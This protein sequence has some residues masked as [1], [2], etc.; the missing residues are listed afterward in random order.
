MSDGIRSASNWIS[1]SLPWLLAT[2]PAYL[3]GHVVRINW[4]EARKDRGYVIP[5]TDRRFAHTHT[6]RPLCFA[7]KMI[8]YLKKRVCIRHHDCSKRG[9]TMLWQARNRHRCWFLDQYPH[10]R[11]S[12]RLVFILPWPGQAHNF[13]I[14]YFD[15]QTRGISSSVTSRKSIS[16]TKIWS[17]LRSASA[18]ASSPG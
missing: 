17:L 15:W 8:S 1:P 3:E 2:Y 10:L 16:C 18:P 11:N 12:P 5:F 14:L 7:E 9:C 6:R 4:G 13:Q